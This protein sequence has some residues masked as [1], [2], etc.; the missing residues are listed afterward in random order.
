ML[1]HCPRVRANFA[2]QRLCL[3]NHG[4]ARLL[5]D[6]HGGTFVLRVEGLEVAETTEAQEEAGIW[7]EMALPEA[8]LLA[9]R[10]ED[11]AGRHSLRLG[12]ETTP[13]V[14]S[15]TPILVAGHIP[16]KQ[17]FVYCEA[18]RLTLRPSGG[19]SMELRVD[20]AFKARRVPCQE[21]DL[22]IHLE[23]AAVCRLL[24]GMLAWS[25]KGE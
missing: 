14:I 1:F 15:E 7:L 22:V 2:A 24:A 9:D 6:E 12:Q 25:R 18:P 17:L 20:G 23:M 3:V 8:A 10:I 5:W 11:F 21:T 4:Q 19:Q 13:E 16:G